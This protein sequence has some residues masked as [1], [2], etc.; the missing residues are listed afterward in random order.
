MNENVEGLRLLDDQPVGL[1]QDRFHH[2][3]YA[4]ILS[5]VFR[6]GKPGLCVG[7]FGKW[8]KG[9]STVVTL[10]REHLKGAAEVV[11]FNAWKAS[12]DSIRRQLLLHVLAKIAPDKASELKRFV[13]VEVVESLLLTDQEQKDQRASARLK[14][15]L[16]WKLWLKVLYATVGK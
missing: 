12:G 4:E 14:T 16:D 7:F 2:Q 6:A 15:A 8:G 3:L 9:K 1:E 11:T 13:G 10:L 5:D